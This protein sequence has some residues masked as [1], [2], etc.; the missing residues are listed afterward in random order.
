MTGRG[1]IGGQGGEWSTL[2]RTASE[3][4]DAKVLQ[5]YQ[6]LEKVGDKPEAHHAIE[7][8]RPRLTILRPPRRPNLSRLF[9][10]PVEDMLD[11]PDSYDRRVNRICRTTLTPCWQA[12]RERMPEKLLNETHRA[13]Q[14]IDLQDRSTLISLMEPLWAAAVVPLITLAEDCAYNLK[15]KI[16][17]FG[18]DD[19]I[20]RQVR[21]I[22]AFMDIASELERLKVALPPKP[23]LDMNEG[24]LDLVR[25]SLN[26]LGQK[27]PEKTPALLMALSSRMQKPGDLMRLVQDMKFAGT[28]QEKENITREVSGY[29]IGNLLRQTAGFD[30]AHGA[31]KAAGDEADRERLA[32]MAERLIDGLNS[33]ND[34]VLSL[35]DKDM[36]VRV[37]HA[38]S[39][40]GHFVV[41]T[42]C[43]GADVALMGTL[44]APDGGPGDDASLKRAEQLALSLHRSARIAPHLG[45]QKEVAAKIHE[46]RHLLEAETLANLRNAPRNRD[47]SVAPEGERQM[48]NSLRILEILAGSEEAERLYKEWRRRLA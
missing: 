38:R 45:I 42:I 15:L 39:E 43:S 22:A 31:P 20:L 48:F 47:G 40:I 18:R 4:S 35:R 11:D 25:Q 37:K 30:R 13:V 24:Q 10:R 32:G 34:L 3:L 8:M 29:V 26:L 28:A 23:I 6:L 9:F 1:G 27:A 46:A 14:L 12:L 21:S 7:A 19:D 16:A 2:Q 17:L 44:F 36:G 5:I 33:V 41:K